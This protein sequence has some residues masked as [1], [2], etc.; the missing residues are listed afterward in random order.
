M[1]AA[2]AIWRFEGLTGTLR[3]CAD[4]M[5]W[6]PHDKWLRWIGTVDQGRWLHVGGGTPREI[7][8]A[9]FPWGSRYI[10]SRTA[11]GA[12]TI[13]TVVGWNEPDRVVSWIAQLDR[14]GDVGADVM[15]RLPRPT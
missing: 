14:Y 13:L 10:Y 9:E 12:E 6:E 1:C 11:G 5:R 3:V 8:E 7:L 4:D 15:R 2:P